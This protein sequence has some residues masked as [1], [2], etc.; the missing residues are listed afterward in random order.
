MPR[1]NVNDIR[2]WLKE[3]NALGLFG[4]DY[5]QTWL[6]G[7]MVYEVDR[8]FGYVVRIFPLSDRPDYDT[9]VQHAKERRCTTSTHT[10]ESGSAVS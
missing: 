8:D 3:K 5:T 1:P 4:G 2:P 7:A 6:V 9:V 10:G